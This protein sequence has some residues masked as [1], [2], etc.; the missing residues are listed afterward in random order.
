MIKSGWMRHN[1]AFTCARVFPRRRLRKLHWKRDALKVMIRD[2]AGCNGQ[3][4]FR[5]ES[6][7]KMYCKKCQNVSK[8]I[9]CHELLFS[10][11]PW[12]QSV[13]NCQPFRQGRHFGLW[14]QL[15][16]DLRWSMDIYEHLWTHQHLGA[17]HKRLHSCSQSPW[18]A[19]DWQVQNH[20][21]KFTKTWQIYHHVIIWSHMISPMSGEKNSYEFC[22][23]SPS[24]NA[25]TPSKNGRCMQHCR[26][27]A[28]LPTTIRLAGCSRPARV[29]KKQWI[30]TRDAKSS[31][32]KATGNR[33]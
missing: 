8:R 32:V 6:P 4:P 24:K 27:S 1:Q 31:I 14:K 23:R 25:A 7:Y 9:L 3:C 33:F 19:G 13:I 30:F 11:D 2:V 22:S 17:V 26:P 29:K 20:I 12:K 16:T 15:E 5:K 10:C 18:Q 21:Q 28:C